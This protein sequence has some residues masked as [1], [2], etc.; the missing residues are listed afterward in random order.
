M[1]VKRWDNYMHL[2]DA[3]QFKCQTLI[4]CTKTSEE[5]YWFLWN[6][7]DC[8]WV[9]IVD[10]G[11]LWDP[12]PKSVAMVETGPRWF[13]WNGLESNPLN[14]R[15]GQ[16]LVNPILYDDHSRI[17]CFFYYN[18][19]NFDWSIESMYKFLWWLLLQVCGAHIQIAVRK[20]EC[21]EEP[22]SKS[23]KRGLY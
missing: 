23:W 11:K 1:G 20:S 15:D 19:M 3:K 8:C 4:Y 6:F 21:N 12:K 18:Q 13:I 10:M 16:R 17:L 22:S 2:E 14:P 9:Y 7:L 5:L